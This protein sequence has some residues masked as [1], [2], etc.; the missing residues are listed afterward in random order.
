MSFAVEQ[1]DDPHGLT[2]ALDRTHTSTLRLLDS[3]IDVSEYWIARWSLSSGGATRR[4]G[5][6]RRRMRVWRTHTHQTQLRDLA[7]RCARVVDESFAAEHKRREEHRGPAAHAASGSLVLADRR[8]G[9]TRTP[10]SPGT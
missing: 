8:V 2:A 6:G 5:G 9:T 1:G 3:I 4:P 7:A 10:E